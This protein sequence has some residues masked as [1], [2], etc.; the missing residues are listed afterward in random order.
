MYI[1]DLPAVGRIPLN[2]KV[3]RILMQSIVNGELPP[4]TKLQ[5]QHVAKQ[6]EVSA[7][8]VREAFKKLAGDGFIEIIPYCGAIV[9]EL[10]ES[11][12]TEAYRCREALERL[13]LEDAM[14][15]FDEE[16][17]NQ[18]Y[19]VAEAG[20]KS[21]DI[22]EIATTN[23]SFHAIIY[24]MANNTMLSKLLDTLNTV[25]ARDMKYSAGNAVRHS[26]I[27]EEHIE[28]ADAIKAHDLARAQQAMINH[29]RNG[30][31]Y[32]QGRREADKVE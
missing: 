12:I 26:Q 30:Q 15:Q 20:K 10:D 8:P 23:Q 1:Q 6:M 2:E 24:G 13:A 19:R 4:G 31:K 18:L 28:I 5:E 27:Y 11:E 17:L 7:T 22:M 9:K 14:D 25:I 3:Y 32:I 29:I 21:K 16:A